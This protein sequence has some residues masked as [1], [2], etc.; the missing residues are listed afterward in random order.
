MKICRISIDKL[1]F[2]G[3]LDGDWIR[4]LPVGTNYRPLGDANLIERVKLSNVALLPPVKP[5]KIVC[6]GRNY[7]AHATELGN[8]IPS[9]PLLF[10]KSPSAIIGHGE[11]IILPLASNRVEYEG[12]LGIVIGRRCSDLA[13]GR[14]IADLVLGFTIVNDVTARDIQRREIQFTRAKSFD[15][16]C[17][18]GPA[19]ETDFDYPAASV[20]TQVNGLVKQRG[21][22]TQMVF[23]IDYLIRYIS[24]QMTLE[25]GDLIATGTPAGVGALS[26]GDFCEV[27]IEGIGVLANN[28][29]R[30][31]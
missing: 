4:P 7:A 27:E 15:T 14:P 9:E 22:A 21:R 17:P 12:E 30:I 29:R 5:S 23:G 20:V 16:F 1:T 3:V 6:V 19:I 24:R 11:T 25:A 10:L 8:D 2:T 18:V 26:E 31:A 28:V 13:D